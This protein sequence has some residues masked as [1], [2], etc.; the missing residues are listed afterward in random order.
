MEIS[1]LYYAAHFFRFPL[2]LCAFASLREI[3][4]AFIRVHSRSLFHLDWVADAATP[5]AFRK[6]IAIALRAGE[7]L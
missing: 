5:L 4:F 6:C 3:L 7:G 1:R 2:K